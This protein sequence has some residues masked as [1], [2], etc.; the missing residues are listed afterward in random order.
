MPFEMFGVS[1]DFPIYVIPRE[2][3]SRTV[4]YTSHVF[5]MIHYD[6]GLQLLDPSSKL[7]FC[8]A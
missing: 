3:V 4:I 6:E 5:D 1:V 7:T 8:F 2:I